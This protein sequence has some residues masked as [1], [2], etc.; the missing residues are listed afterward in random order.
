MPKQD[1]PKVRKVKDERPKADVVKDGDVIK[2][3][4]KDRVKTFTVNNVDAKRPDN[5]RTIKVELA[6]GKTITTD[7]VE[8]WQEKLDKDIEKFKD[9]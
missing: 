2:E 6:N 7:A 3:K 8:G 4:H 5:P 1:I 9:R